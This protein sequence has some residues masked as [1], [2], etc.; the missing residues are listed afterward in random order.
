PTVSLPANYS[1]GFHWSLSMF[2]L[3]Q[4]GMICPLGSTRDEIKWRMLDLAH[5]GIAVTDTYSPGNPLPLGQ[6][7]TAL[8]PM[9]ELPLRDRSRNNQLALGALTEI[10]PAVDAAIEHY[11]ADRIAVVIGTSTSGTADSESG[12]RH[13]AITGMLPEQFHYGQ[14]ELGSPAMM[15]AAALG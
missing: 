10:R 12:L 14:Q 2:Y 15:L 5:S 1:V 7:I 13:Y 6:V 8:P 9:D 3:N 4:L 11:G